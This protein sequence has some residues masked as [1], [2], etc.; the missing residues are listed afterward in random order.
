MFQVC[1]LVAELPHF[2][3]HSLGAYGVGV[4]DEDYDWTYRTVYPLRCLVIPLTA[5]SDPPTKSG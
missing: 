2:R 5:S 1:V 4:G 3:H